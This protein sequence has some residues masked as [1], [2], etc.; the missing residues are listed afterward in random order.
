M[1][2][3]IYV[4]SSA[5]KLN[6]TQAIT[7]KTE[8]RNLLLP[9]LGSSVPDLAPVVFWKSLSPFVFILSPFCLYPAGSPLPAL[10]FSEKTD[11]LGVRVEH[12]QHRV[13]LSLERSDQFSYVQFSSGDEQMSL[14]INV[15]MDGDEGNEGN[16]NLSLSHPTPI[17]YPTHS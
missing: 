6:I 5:E 4:S 14:Y 7:K 11:S 3:R 8:S 2:G 15:R 10:I 9:A 16:R 13:N 17:L 1:V 12:I